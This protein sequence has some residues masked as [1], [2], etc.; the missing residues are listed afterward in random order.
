MSKNQWPLLGLLLLVVSSLLLTACGPAAE[1]VAQA[2]SEP[3]GKLAAAPER[4]VTAMVQVATVKKGDIAVVYNYAGTLQA[5]Q[6]VNVMPLTSGR[7]VSVQVNE[8]DHLKAGDP[9]AVVDNRNYVAQL[10]QAQA[11]L[12]QNQLSLTKMREGT[13]PEQI[14]AAS[15]AVQFA[16]NAVNDVNTITDQQRTSFVAALAQAQTALQAAQTEYDKISWAGNVGMTPQGIALQSATV[17]YQKAQADYYNNTHPR[18]SALSPMLSQLAQAELALALAKQ[19][20]TQTDYDLAQAKVDQAQAAVELAQ[21]QLGETVIR[22]PF[23]GVVAEVNIN[24]G[25]IVGPQTQVALFVSKETE[26][27][28]N[29]EESRISQ[30]SAGQNAAVRVTAYPNQDFPAVVTDVAPIADA[31]THTFA[32]RVTAVDPQFQLRAGMYADLSL[33]AQDRQ[34]ALLVPRTAIAMADGKGTVYVVQGDQTAKRQQVTTGLIDGDN[35]EVIS[36]LKVGDKVVVAG[37]TGLADGATVE[38]TNAG[39]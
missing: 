24:E 10:K 37:Q 18:D 33:L 25:N 7:I 20:Y 4:V 31:N 32:V 35:V 29:V 9:I 17:A 2:A 34:G 6:S 11:L 27:L 13:R 8:G 36:G 16:R 15:A 3:A 30:V 14:A 19:P 26:A 23:D 28:V 21:V 5:K 39:L 38:V 1:P 22:A 12:A